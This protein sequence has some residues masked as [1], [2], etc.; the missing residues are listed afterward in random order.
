MQT[1]SERR[2]S[3]REFV[4]QGEANYVDRYL[5]R[6]KRR[7]RELCKEN[8]LHRELAIKRENYLERE[9]ITQKVSYRE[10]KLHR[11]M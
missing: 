7:Q 1:E 9:L 10:S 2:E 11:I 3:Y 8:Q 5:S 6:E 4:M